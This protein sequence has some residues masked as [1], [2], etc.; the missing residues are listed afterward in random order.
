MEVGITT[1]IDGTKLKTH[2]KCSWEVLRKER[3]AYFFFF[4]L[5]SSFFPQLLI[6]HHHLKQILKEIIIRDRAAVG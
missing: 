2:R 6:S 5:F 3:M 4:F 1:M